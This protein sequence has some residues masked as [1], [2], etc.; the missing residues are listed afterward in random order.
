MACSNMLYS[1]DRGDAGVAVEFEKSEVLILFDGSEST[2]IAY[3]LG[4]RAGVMAEA[5]DRI[6]DSYQ[7]RIAFGF[8]RFPD[9][10]ACGEGASPSCCVGNRASVDIGLNQG[11]AIHAAL[12]NRP[13]PQGGSPMALAL[14][15]AASIFQSRPYDGANRLVLLATDGQPGCGTA[16][17]SASSNGCQEAVQ[18]VQFLA[19]L[20]PPVRTLVLS[21][22]AGDPMGRSDCLQPLAQAAPP[23]QGRDASIKSDGFSTD[24]LT[25]LEAVLESTFVSGPV[26]HPSCEVVLWPDPVNNARV[27]VTIDDHLIP[28]DGY[29]GWVLQ[30]SRVSGPDGGRTLATVSL[31]GQYCKRLQQFRYNKVEVTYDCLP[32]ARLDRPRI[33]QRAHYCKT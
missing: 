2:G 15:T 16:D 22:G 26:V 20:N 31:R 33:G 24:D 13:L 3:G 17:A 10:A 8:L 19:N 25:S 12:A 1:N 14:Q 4:T 30:T 9:A 11:A 29:N 7:G 6:V 21:P 23:T 27:A 32:I 18:A 5:I 28:E